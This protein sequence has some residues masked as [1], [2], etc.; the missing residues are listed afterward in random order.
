MNSAYREGQEDVPLLG[1]GQIVKAK[2]GSRESFIR[3]PFAEG[4]PCVNNGAIDFCG[5]HF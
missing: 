2:E 4:P 1:E 5:D 3:C